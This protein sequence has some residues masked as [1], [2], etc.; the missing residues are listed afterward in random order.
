VR[1]WI[2][3]FEARE[4]HHETAKQRRNPRRGDLRQP[5]E[6]ASKE[7]HHEDKGGHK[8]MV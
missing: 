8:E 7:Q 2:C 1:L 4:R 6:A 5:V 3:E